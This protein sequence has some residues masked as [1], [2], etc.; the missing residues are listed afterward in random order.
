ML[1]DQSAQANY[2]LTASE[3]AEL[4]HKRH[5]AI[6]E[7]AGVKIRVRADRFVQIDSHRGSLLCLIINN[8]VCNAVEASQSGQTVDVS[9]SPINNSLQVSVADEGSGIPDNVRDRLFTPGCSG[10]AGGTGL[11]LTISQLLS[12]Q[13]GATLELVTT[14]NQGTVF[15]VTMPLSS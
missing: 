12:R 7:A 2:E 10:R 4:I 5:A 13:I 15:R 3:L 11:G 6:A 9:L 1:S 14:G 8:L